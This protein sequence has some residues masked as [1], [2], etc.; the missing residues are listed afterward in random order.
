MISLNSFL[1]LINSYFKPYLKYFC[2]IK[3]HNNH[4][5]DI[6]YEEI[7]GLHD[8]ESIIFNDF[9]NDNNN[10]NIIDR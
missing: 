4:N 1:E 5:D 9:Q 6:Y 2:M 7:Y 8:D 3:Q 10:K